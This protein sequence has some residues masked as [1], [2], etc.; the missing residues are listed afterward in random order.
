MPRPP[1][2]AIAGGAVTLL[3]ASLLFTA[4][5]VVVP[6]AAADLPSRG[7][8]WIEPIM[9]VVL[10]IAT[11]AGG[12]AWIVEA[13]RAGRPAAVLTAAS[14]AALAGAAIVVIA[15][16]AD[17]VGIPLVMAAAL[18][19]A[20]GVAGRTSVA[21]IQRS[22]HRLAAT[23]AGLAVAELAAAAGALAALDAVA[24]PLRLTA[25]GISVVTVLATAGTRSGAEAVAFASG[26]LVLAIGAGGG[27]TAV[28]LAAFV[29]AS[30]FGA[31]RAIGHPEIPEPREPSDERLPELAARL[32]DAV[33][34]FDGRL[35][36]VDWNAT[37][38]KL[39]GLDAASRGAR[40]EDLLGIPI[41]GLPTHDGLVTAERGVGGL[42]IAIHRSGG[43][44]T[45]IV[46]DPA[47][48]PETERLTRELRGTI[49]EL[50][51]ARRT[52][53]LQRAEIERSATIDP[54]TGLPARPAILERL[55]YEIEEASRYR[56]PIAVVLLDLDGFTQLNRDHGTGAGDA[57]LREVA[58]RIRLR[59]RTADALGRCGGD[60]FLAILPHTDEGGAATFADALRRRLGARPISAG[61]ADVTVTASA[62]VAIMRS[63]E[64]IDVDGLLARAE[65]ALASAT[66]AGGDR[67]ALDR[68]HGLARLDPPES[69]ADEPSR[70]DRS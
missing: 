58:L 63:G 49:E 29:A 48:A 55:R 60:A 70:A 15:V 11:T 8:A 44:M 18:Q 31:L 7:L 20:A 64:A 19:L 33:L 4:V 50:V 32:A 30:L 45:A 59:V 9:A 68:L 57:V 51:Q 2:S 47:R 39:L 17:A 41:S 25:L 35:R 28:A 26:A 13:L 56:H 23:A 46:R 3:L 62:G 69:A 37:A 27:A 22:A 67:I 38:A 14:V 6:G 21:P 34:R 65:E 36:L 43:G 52:I 16:D 10:V 66:A 53:E 40:L 12:L 1:G 5:I 42:D 54:L 24:D 61:G